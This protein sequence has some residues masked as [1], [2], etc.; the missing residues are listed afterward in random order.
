M[1][2]PSGAIFL[3]S[4]NFL[5]RGPYRHHEDD[6]VIQSPAFLAS[7]AIGPGLLRSELGLPTAMA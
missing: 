5:A 3:D 4:K 1:A 7:F 2:R 6:N